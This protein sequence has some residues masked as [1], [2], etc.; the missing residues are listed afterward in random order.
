LF[1]VSNSTTDRWPF[2]RLADSDTPSSAPA[3]DG[4]RLI[5]IR[6]PDGGPDTVSIMHIS[7]SS[8]S[9]VGLA[10]IALRCTGTLEVNTI[11]V[12]IEPWP[13]SSH[14]RVTL[15]VGSKN[16]TF[17]ATVLQPFTVLLLPRAATSLLIESWQTDPSL[18]VNI[19]GPTKRTNGIVSIANLGPAF[20]DLLKGCLTP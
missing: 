10:G 6:N 11:V 7:D 13:P 3:E 1:T 20:D 5:R 8:Q 4:W 15:S 16:A 2:H 14:P 18:S 19:E 12:V 17:D 9:D